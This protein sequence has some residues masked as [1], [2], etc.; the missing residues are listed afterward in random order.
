MI[1][2]ILGEQHSEIIQGIRSY[3]LYN[4]EKE[5]IPVDES[6]EKI[7]VPNFLELRQKAF[8][9]ILKKGFSQITFVS[10]NVANCIVRV[11]KKE[12]LHHGFYPEQVYNLWGFN[13]FTQEDDDTWTS[14]AGKS[15]CITKFELDFSQH[16]VE[17]GISQDEIIHCNCDFFDSYVVIR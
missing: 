8:E 15:P 14:I 7:Y 10:P 9:E 17:Q 2:N 16:E 3:D 6:G 1:T 5:G 12:H 4:Y 11:F 13:C